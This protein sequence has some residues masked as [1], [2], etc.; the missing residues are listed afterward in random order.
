MRRT[1]AALLLLAA[2]PAGAAEPSPERSLPEATERLRQELERAAEAM[3]ESMG[4]ILLSLEDVA[5]R[6]PRYEPPEFNE[7]GD[8]IIRRKPPLGKD[9]HDR[10]GTI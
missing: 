1:L 8:I 6:L 9:R 10:D 2:I 7:N 5:R 4:K 3:R